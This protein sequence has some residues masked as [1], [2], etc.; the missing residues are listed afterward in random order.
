MCRY[1]KALQQL[2]PGKPQIV[3]KHQ[4]TKE[5]VVALL[6]CGSFVKGSA[7]VADNF[8][9]RIQH[10]TGYEAGQSVQTQAKGRVLCQRHVGFLY[11]CNVGTYSSVTHVHELKRKSKKM[12]AT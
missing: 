6:D 11:H 1:C 2:Y 10:C 9:W 4:V 7:S 5:V 12:I 3:S 8:Q